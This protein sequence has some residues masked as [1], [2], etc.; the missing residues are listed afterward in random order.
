MPVVLHINRLIF[1]KKKENIDD[2]PKDDYPRDIKNIKSWTR[3]ELE[4]EY[5]KLIELYK[6]IYDPKMS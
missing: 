4:K 2:Y 5:I 3:E 6:N 1:V